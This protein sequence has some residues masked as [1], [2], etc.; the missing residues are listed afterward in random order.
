M[1]AVWSIVFLLAAAAGARAVDVDGFCER[2]PAHAPDSEASGWFA[3]PRQYCDA[4]INTSSGSC[5]AS[6]IG[7]DASVYC[8][9]AFDLGAGEAPVPLLYMRDTSPSWIWVAAKYVSPE[10][11][12]AAPEAS[13]GHS[14]SFNYHLLQPLLQRVAARAAD[15]FMR[16]DES[17]VAA[18]MSSRHAFHAVQTNILSGDPWFKDTHNDSG[19]LGDWMVPLHSHSLVPDAQQ[20]MTT[21]SCGYSACPLSPE[22]RAFPCDLWTRLFMSCYNGNASH[23]DLRVNWRLRGGDFFTTAK[24]HSIWFKLP[25]ALLVHTVWADSRAAMRQG[26]VD[27]MQGAAGMRRMSQLHDHVVRTLRGKRVVMLGDSNMRYQYLDLAYFACF[28]VW[29]SLSASNEQLQWLWRVSYLWDHDHAYSQTWHESFLK[30]TA[31]FKGLQQCD[32][33]RPSKKSQNWKRMSFESR[34][35]RCD[36]ITL[37]Y[38]QFFGRG[39]HVSGRLP[40]HAASFHD[41]AVNRFRMERVCGNGS[42]SSSSSSSGVGDVCLGD[43]RFLWG[44]DVMDCAPPGVTVFDVLPPCDA[45]WQMDLLQFLRDLGSSGGGVDLLVLNYGVYMIAFFLI[46]LCLCRLV[47]CSLAGAHAGVERDAAFV[48]EVVAAGAAAV[49]PR[50]GTAVWKT[51]Y[52]VNP[53]WFEDRHLDLPVTTRDLYATE[54]VRMAGSGDAAEAELARRWSLLDAE[55]LT[56]LLTRSG[57]EDKFHVKNW[58]TGNIN[59]VLLQLLMRTTKN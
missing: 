23:A 25:A 4:I 34:V 38:H 56:C 12:H 21:D 32:C 55:A 48:R 10:S 36:G 39:A 22:W 40:L 16:E 49:A 52:I 2:A 59:V 33:Y 29:P 43:G 54:L 9:G 35:T 5:N 30:S 57:F 20:L 17:L 50:Q 8:V 7:A 13:S 1:V 37:E 6:V 41:A 3:A 11:A 27:G 14:G 24:A 46:H 19:L 26:Y 47:T 18:V 44:G 58:V 42:A 45:P 53:A 51:S 31:L 28:G 15:I